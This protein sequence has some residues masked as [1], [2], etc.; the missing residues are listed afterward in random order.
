METWTIYTAIYAILNGFYE[1]GKKKAAEKNSVYEV[2]ALM[3]GAACILAIVTCKNVFSVHPL[4]ILAVF[5]KS[6]MVV[7]AW[8]VSLYVVKEMTM[9]LYGVINLSRILFTI[10]M[11]AILL[12]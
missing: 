5:I 10:A 6:L 12:G 1:C 8:T 7:I 11:S 2:L 3:T 4:I 9:S